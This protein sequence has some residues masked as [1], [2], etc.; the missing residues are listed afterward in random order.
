MVKFLLGSPN[1]LS[2]LLNEYFRDIGIAANI[3]LYNSVLNLFL[4]DLLSYKP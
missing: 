2:Q 3:S 4:S 1:H